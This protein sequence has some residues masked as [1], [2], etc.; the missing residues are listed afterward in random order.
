MVLFD[1]PGLAAPHDQVGIGKGINVPVKDDSLPY[2]VGITSEFEPLYVIT[3]EIS[4][5]NLFIDTGEIYV[6]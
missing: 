3:D 5:Q 1:D 6:C 2:H 4:D